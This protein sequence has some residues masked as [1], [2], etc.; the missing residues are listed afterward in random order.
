MVLV[1]L[2]LHNWVIFTANVGKYSS[3]MEHLGKGKYPK[4]AVEMTK[5][6]QTIGYW[7]TLFEFTK[8]LDAVQSNTIVGLV[9]GVKF[10]TV[11]IRSNY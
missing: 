1:Y 4:K 8:P 7:G 9:I 3:T 2:Y 5:L 6:W 10:A 11:V